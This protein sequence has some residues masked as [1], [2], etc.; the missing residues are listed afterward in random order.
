LPA[1]AAARE[2]KLVRPRVEWVL[3]GVAEYDPEAATAIDVSPYGGP[4]ADALLRARSFRRLIAA[5]GQADLDYDPATGVD[6]RPS[7]IS[8]IPH[9]GPVDVVLAFDAIDRADDVR[10]LAHA[11]AEVL[12]PGGLLFATASNASGFELQVLWDRSPTVAPPDKLNLLS[13]EG[14]R[15]TFGPPAWDLLELSTPGMFDVEMVRRGVQAEPTYAWPR[16]IHRLVEQD[17]AA[18]VEFQEYLQ[19]HRL[20]SFARLV[21]QRAA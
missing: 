10:A 3:E 16:F 2:E 8:G 4:L 12:R 15:R 19:R 9:L 5:S 21:A 11:A 17:E 1:T 13:A 6:I 7:P 20:A 18:A 14:L